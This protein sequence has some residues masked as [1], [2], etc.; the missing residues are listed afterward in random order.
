[1]TPHLDRSR[2]AP[3]S[4]L[5][6]AQQA[7]QEEHCRMKLPLAVRRQRQHACRD[8][9]D[10]SEHRGPGLAL[11]CSREAAAVEFTEQKRK[12]LAGRWTLMPSTRPPPPGSQRAHSLGW[13]H[14]LLRAASSL[15]PRHASCP[16]IHPV[17]AWH[18][19]SHPAN[20]HHH[21]H[22]LVTGLKPSSGSARL[23]WASNPGLS[24]PPSRLPFGSPTPGAKEAG[25]FPPQRV[26]PDPRAR[27]AP[28]Q[29]SLILREGRLALAGG[30][31][32]VT[33]C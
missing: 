6:G 11:L 16:H 28:E 18:P 29:V 30:G 32:G 1:M 20:H 17:G 22:E 31:N 19:P 33:L 24:D 25:T 27:Q 7:G 2:G 13:G 12:V 15:P 23:R 4:G 5:L 8:P 3:A 21:T 14:I 9:L 10:P 26:A